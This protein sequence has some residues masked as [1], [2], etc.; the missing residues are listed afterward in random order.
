MFFVSQFLSLNFFQTMFQNIFLIQDGALIFR[1]AARAWIKCSNYNCQ[2]LQSKII[3][4]TEWEQRNTEWQAMHKKCYLFHLP[5][6][7]LFPLIFVIHTLHFFF[8][9]VQLKS[10]V[11]N[12]LKKFLFVTFHSKEKNWPKLHF[13]NF[14]AC[15]NELRPTLMFFL[16]N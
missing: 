16:K 7:I 9:V 10:F 5:P 3:S 14:S 13:F 12:L 8:S 6:R 11:I 4:F 1:E 15:P 2:T